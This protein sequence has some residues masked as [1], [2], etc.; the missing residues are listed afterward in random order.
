MAA[1]GGLRGPTIAVRWG[2]QQ[3]LV[4]G[5]YFS[6]LGTK[7]RVEC[8]N[9]GVC[10][11]DQGTCVCY[12]GYASSD[13]QGNAGTIG[14]C[15]HRQYATY[16]YTLVNST[17]V[18]HTPCPF[19]HNAVCSG[20]GTCDT[21]SGQCTCYPG[22]GES[23]GAHA[24]FQPSHTI[25]LFRWAGVRQP[26]VQHHV[27]VVRQHRRAPPGRL[28]L[29]RRGRVRRKLRQVHV[30]GCRER[31]FCLSFVYLTEIAA[32]RSASSTGTAASTC[33]ARRLAR[34]CAGAISF[35]TLHLCDMG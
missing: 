16:N 1:A 5:N 35:T 6:A 19:A 22:Y 13:G 23:S 11:Y 30:R 15:G 32:E 18:V 28:G 14:D 10:N 26:D 9:H 24:R 17:T 21:A 4:D 33:R 20:N 34:T 2:G 12:G 7:E 27:H 25:P 29:R 3:S 8:S 31:R